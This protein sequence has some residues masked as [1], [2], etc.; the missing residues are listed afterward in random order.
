MYMALFNPLN[1][2]VS[3][4]R[5]LEYKQYLDDMR[6]RERITRD[7]GKDFRLSD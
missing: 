6:A 4:Q 1:A 5:I 2:M 3:D 7:D